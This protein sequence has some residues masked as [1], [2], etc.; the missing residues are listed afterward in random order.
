VQIKREHIPAVF[1][2]NIYDPRLIERIAEESGAKIGGTLYSD[3]LS[4]PNGPAA[5]Y[6]AMMR[7]NARALVDA[8]AP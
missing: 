4:P 2:E 3:A 6:I 1:I 8:L 7:H 5:T